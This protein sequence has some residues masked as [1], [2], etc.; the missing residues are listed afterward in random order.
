MDPDLVCNL[1]LP[2]SLQMWALPRGN[3]AADEAAAQRYLDFKLGIYADPLWF[4]SVS[5]LVT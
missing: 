4:A 5:M 1:T 3:T 2:F